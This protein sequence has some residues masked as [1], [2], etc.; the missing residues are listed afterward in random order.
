MN[1]TEIFLIAMAVIFAVPWLIWRVARTDYWAPLVVVQIVGGILLGP[2]VLGAV[3]PDYYA[4]VFQ[5]DVIIAL[6]GVAWWAVMLFVMIAGIELDLKKAWAHR[7]ESTITAV[8]LT[9]MEPIFSLKL[10]WRFS[11]LLWSRNP[12]CRSC[13]NASS[14]LPVLRVSCCCCKSLPVSCC[15]RMDAGAMGL[16]CNAN[17][18]PAEFPYMAANGPRNT[19]TAANCSNNIL[20][21]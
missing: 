19:S 10:A 7:R 8:I 5:P 1:T 20:P 9:V 14:V 3:F 6:N 4:F 13:L 18:P 21:G 15:N 2:G 11:A 17:T 12:S 16:L